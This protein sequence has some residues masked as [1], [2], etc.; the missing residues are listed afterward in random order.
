MTAEN[1]IGIY[2]VHDNYDRPFRVVVGE[3]TD[4]IPEVNMTSD[5]PTTS[6]DQLRKYHI[7]VYKRTEY[8]SASQTFQYLDH[9]CVSME[10]NQLFIGKSPVNDV[11]LF[12][13][14][15]G[16]RF[17]GNTILF[18]CP[19]AED[20]QNHQ[21]HQQHPYVYIGENI[22]MFY[23]KGRIVKYRS[24]VGNNDCPYP[25]AIDEH[26][27]IYLF[28]ENVVLAPN[29]ATNINDI[30]D[31]TDIYEYYYDKCKMAMPRREGQDERTYMGIS[32]LM[33]NDVW[34]VLS[35]RP[36]PESSKAYDR[37]TSEGELYAVIDSLKVPMSK[38]RYLEL[39]RNYGIEHG[40]E[41]LNIFH[42]IP[43]IER[44]SRRSIMN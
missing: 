4:T 10:T 9:A 3:T 40:F 1:S 14:G 33:V 11:T 22:I 17:D 24:D 16:D 2:H 7:H 13:G 35:Y 8:D 19:T 27:Y 39:I 26:N 18:R 29:F 30:T 20:P 41:Q 42:E 44:A 38:E 5:A 28:A 32:A 43:Q 21:Q 37:I 12:S 31:D 6:A 25:F 34:F 36:A 15:H 23:A